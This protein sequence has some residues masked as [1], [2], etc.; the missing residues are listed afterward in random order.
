MGWWVGRV[1]KFGKQPINL[2]GQVY[3]NSVDKDDE[4]SPEWTYKVNMTF[5]FPA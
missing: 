4:I 3:Y 1:T 5:L 2:F